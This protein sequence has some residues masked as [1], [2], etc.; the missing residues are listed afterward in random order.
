MLATALLLLLGAQNPPPVVVTGCLT[1]ATVA[2]QPQFTLTTTDTNR[3]AGDVKTETYQL[4][5]AP[6]VDLKSMVGRRIEVTG[7]ESIA[8]AEN[9]TVDDSRVTEKARGT[10][11][12]TP[13]VETKTRADIVV[14]QMNVTA[15]KA[16]AGDCRVP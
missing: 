1:S 7:K 13:T 9:T 14:H 6:N 15:A 12:K 11:G 8:G 16:V 2:G 3:A 10:S 4:K 5:A